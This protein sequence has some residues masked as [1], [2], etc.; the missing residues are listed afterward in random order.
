MLSGRERE[1]Q[2]LT[3]K[4]ET[5][6]EEG[7]SVY[8]DAD[9]LAD[10]AD[11]YASNIRYEQ[12][13]DAVEYGLRLHPGNTDLLVEQSYLYLDTQQPEEAER[14]AGTITDDYSPA[15]TVLKASLLLGK[16]QE[17]ASEALLNELDDPDD[18]AN[19]VDV[20]YMYLDRGYPEKAWEWIRRG[21]NIY[22]DDDSY[23]AVSADC[24]YAQ[25]EFDEAAR[26]YNLLIDHNP[27]ASRAWYGL[28]QCHVR[29]EEYD[30]TVEAC[31]YAIVTDEEYGEAY[32]LRGYAYQF[33]GNTEKALENYRLAIEYDAI[34]PAFADSYE[35]I[36]LGEAGECER[37]IPLLERAIDSGELDGEVLLNTYVSLGAC[38][39]RQEDYARSLQVLT[40]ALELDPEDPLIHVTIGGLYMAEDKPDKALRNFI[41]AL[42]LAPYASTWVEI[43]LSCLESG[44]TN[45]ARYALRHAQKMEPDTENFYEQMATAYLFLRD[46]ENFKKYNSLS[47]HPVGPELMP[48]LDEA[49]DK[50]DDQEWLEYIK[51]IIQ[52][53]RNPPFH[54][55]EN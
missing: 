38:Y 47:Q 51:E 4:Y 23:I 36:C 34:S 19:I 42:R 8:M 20:A 41:Q 37:A 30:K 52:V 32:F 22:Y 43:A 16:G 33:L 9:E 53:L 24:R 13:F 15:V 10:V 2:E 44:K 21:E 26:L 39:A 48:R 45:F 1:L 11:W 54:I 27:Y 12:A 55:S 14:I 18:L 31:D 35:G 50:A 3:E 17:E 25:E 46:K 7:R 29:K 40:E 49:F 28:A 6:R 5:A